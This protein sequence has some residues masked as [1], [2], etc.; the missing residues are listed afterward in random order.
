MADRKCTVK[1]DPEGVWYAR[2]YLGRDVRGKPIKPYKRFADAKTREEAQAMA[3]AWVAKLSAD[4]MV[5]SAFVADL[6]DEYITMRSRTG[7]AK[8]TVA[9]WRSCAKHVRRYLD[10]AVLSDVTTA[11]LQQFEGAL[12][13]PKTCGGQGLCAN[14]VINVHTL[15]KLAFAYFTRIGLRASNPMLDVIEPKPERREAF[16][17]DMYDFERLDAPLESMWR[18]GDGATDTMRVYAFAAW[19]ALRSGLRCGEMCAITRREVIRYPQAQH[20]DEHLHVVGNV[21]KDKGAPAYRVDET[22]TRK[23]RD[24]PLSAQTLAAVDDFIAIQD[25]W[26][27]GFTPDTPLVTLDGSFCSP[28]AVSRGFSRIR[29]R[30]KLPRKLTF[31]KLRHTYATWALASGRITVNNLAEWLGHSDPSI[32]VSRYGHAM[33]KLNKESIEA[34]DAVYSKLKGCVTNE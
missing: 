19:L 27:L 26:G 15:M 25:S 4:G 2:P 23:S 7:I 28:D 24:V 22:K 3:D 1:L 33:P 5:R 6:V 30:L 8:S 12:K 10:S 14:T 17:L 31:H 29:D 21:L 32:T 18:T 34:L 16:S 9:Q 11:D 20:G 13:E